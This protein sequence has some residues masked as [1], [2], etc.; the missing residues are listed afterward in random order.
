MSFLRMLEGGRVLAVFF[1]V[2][3]LT[4]TGVQILGQVNIHPGACTRFQHRWGAN[5]S[6]VLFFIYSVYS[7][8]LVFHFNWAL[9]NLGFGARI[10]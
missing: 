3:L 7:A 4:E 10:I 6:P 9:R 5:F 8:N 2:F 1:L